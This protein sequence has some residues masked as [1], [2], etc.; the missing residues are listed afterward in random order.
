MHVMCCSHTS[1]LHIILPLYVTFVVIDI[2]KDKDK[3][4]KITCNT[5]I[6][7]DANC[8][9]LGQQKWKTLNTNSLT[10]DSRFAQPSGT[11]VSM[12]KAD[13]AST[14]GGSYFTVFIVTAVQK[15]TF[16]AFYGKG[17]TIAPHCHLSIRQW[18]IT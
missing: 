5:H 2:D 4:I 6:V 18:L 3:D 7:I 1:I 17:E 8:R 11:Q 12:S 16:S 10:C 15:I 14:A 9:S 13:D